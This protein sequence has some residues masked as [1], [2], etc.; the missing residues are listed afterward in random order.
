MSSSRDIINNKCILLVIYQ[1]VFIVCQ[2]LS[3]LK[4]MNQF[5]PV[6]SSSSYCSFSSL[7]FPYFLL[8]SIHY[9]LASV[10]TKI[11][12]SKA[13]NQHFSL[14]NL[15]ANFSFVI[16]PD[17]SSTFDPV[18]HVVLNTLSSFDFYDNPVC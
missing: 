8:G 5:S 2:G 3:H 12:F 11:G 17:L 7:S 4:Q 14:L 15:T 1:L 10:P 13:I 9:N 6:P 16:F 18:D